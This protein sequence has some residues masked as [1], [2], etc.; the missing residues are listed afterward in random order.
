MDPGRVSSGPGPMQTPVPLLEPIGTVL[1]SIPNRNFKAGEDKNA[2][3]H[4]SDEQSRP[5]VLPK[6]R[7]A[8]L[9][10]WRV[11]LPAI[12]ENGPRRSLLARCYIQL[13]I[14][15]RSPGGTKVVVPKTRMSLPT[16]SRPRLLPS[17][18][19][20]VSSAQRRVPGALLIP[21]RSRQK[22]LP[23]IGRSHV[24]S[25]T[26]PRYDLAAPSGVPQYNMM[27]LGARSLPQHQPL[28][29]SSQDHHRSMSR[30]PL[31]PASRFAL[32]VGPGPSGLLQNAQAHPTTMRRTKQSLSGVTRAMSNEP[33]RKRTDAL[34]QAQNVLHG[35]ESTPEQLARM[36][37]RMLNRASVQKCRHRQSERAKRLQ[38]ERSTLTR[39]NAVLRRA[40]VYVEQSGVFDIFR[41]VQ[42]AAAAGLDPTLV[43]LAYYS[44]PQRNQS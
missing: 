9:D 26:I 27:P 21:A 1:A 6:D 18:S 40:K 38:Q 33:E 3:M 11:L 37:R 20:Q 31:R 12:P 5:L 2:M 15:S 16:P 34:V 14:S 24:A 35:N 25:D 41:R 7:S 4:V 10:S 29:H 44:Q 13:P 19:T 43:V 22:S 30:H 8:R 36:T 17:R 32:P 39:E 23:R 42:E 28:S